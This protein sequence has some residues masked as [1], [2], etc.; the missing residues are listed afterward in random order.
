MRA[1]TT[2]E[3]DAMAEISTRKLRLETIDGEEAVFTNRGIGVNRFAVANSVQSLT[4]DRH[5]WENN[6]RPL[7][8]DAEVRISN[9]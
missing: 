1:H 4:V 6:G 7:E 9:G 3:V 5:W 2:A 8:V